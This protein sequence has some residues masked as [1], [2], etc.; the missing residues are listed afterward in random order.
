MLGNIFIGVFKF[1][2]GRSLRKLGKDPEFLK[3]VAALNHHQAE[4]KRMT[5]EFEKEHGIP[6]DEW[7]LKK[8]NRTYHQP[9]TIGIH[10]DSEGNIEN[11]PVDLIKIAKEINKTCPKVIDKNVR[12]D[13]AEMDD[14]GYLHYSYT[15]TMNLKSD[16]DTDL[17]SKLLN[18]Q[19][20]SEGQ[21]FFKEN[22]VRLKYT[23]LDMR[24]NHIIS[25]I[26]PNELLK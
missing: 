23:Y 8:L 16:M 19:Y 4:V 26:V 20:H 17:L 5:A 9:S 15:M 21:R 7:R 6:L 13:Y 12:L 14:N 11:E 3:N 18:E 10:R 24:N 2:V 1:F 22:D 25:I